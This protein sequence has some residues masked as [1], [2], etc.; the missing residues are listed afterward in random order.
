MNEW[1]ITSRINAWNDILYYLNKRKDIKWNEIIWFIWHDMGEMNWNHMEKTNNKTWNK[2]NE[3]QWHEVKWGEITWV[4]Y[5][6]IKRN[7]MNELKW[8]DMALMKWN[9][10]RWKKIQWHKMKG[11]EQSHTPSKMPSG[12][13]RPAVPASWH[14]W[15]YRARSRKSLHSIPRHLVRLF[16][17]QNCPGSLC[18]FVWIL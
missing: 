3:I 12:P 16:R 6:D 13:S 8:K 5:N 18:N 14:S 11:K 15:L 17:V 9:E 10:R 1:V 7:G 2:A 4:K